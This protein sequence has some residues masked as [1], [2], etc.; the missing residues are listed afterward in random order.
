MR[1][2]THLRALLG[3]AILLF[4]STSHAQPGSV[5]FAF[6]PGSSVDFTIFPVALQSNGKIIIG[7]SFGTPSS[8]LARLNADGSPDKSFNV[9]AGASP[10]FGYTGG[11][12]YIY[13]MAVQPDDKIIIGGVFNTFNGVAR[14][15]IARLNADGSV[16]LSF[17]PGEGIGSI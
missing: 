1:I 4:G 8:G 14:T 15:N 11:F 2:A 6:D 3:I 7:G 12:N 16:D 9:G 17:D 5:D 10:G 13:A